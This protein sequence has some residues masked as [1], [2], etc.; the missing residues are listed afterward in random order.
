M[1]RSVDTSVEESENAKYRATDPSV[2]DDLDLPRVPLVAYPPCAQCIATSSQYHPD[3]VH[4]CFKCHLHGC[5]PY[6]T[7]SYHRWLHER[8]PARVNRVLYFE[9][10][11]IGYVILHT[12]DCVTLR[13]D[14]ML[15]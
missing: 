12:P 7:K 14:A 4:E 3:I 8:P 1:K 5:R 10:P 9:K 13:R 15:L 6:M 11:P 2:P